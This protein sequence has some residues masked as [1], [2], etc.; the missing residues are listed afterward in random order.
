MGGG[1]YFYRVKEGTCDMLRKGTYVN[2]IGQENIFPAKTRPI[3]DI[4]PKLDQEIC[5]SCAAR[6]FP[7]CQ[8]Q[9]PDGSSRSQ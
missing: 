4:Y 1:L 5:R 2:A 7:E 6:I 3:A 8:T 9:L